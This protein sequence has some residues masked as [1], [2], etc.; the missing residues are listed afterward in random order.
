MGEDSLERGG[1]PP[2]WP[3]GCCPG[4][5]NSDWSSIG[6]PVGTIIAG[7]AMA[8]GREEVTNEDATGACT[9]IASEVAVVDTTNLGMGTL[10]AAGLS[11]A[12]L[13]ATGLRTTVVGGAAVSGLDEQCPP[14]GDLGAASG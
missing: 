7:H 8:I 6:G 3:P 10:A 11:T 14:G 5:A 2:H 13:W 12:L 4:R 9:G 1:D